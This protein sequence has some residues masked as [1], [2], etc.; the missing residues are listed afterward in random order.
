MEAG[1][2]RPRCR[3]SWSRER[4]Q[5][6]FLRTKWLVML[7][8]FCEETFLDR[9]PVCDRCDR[10]S[11]ASGDAGSLPALLSVGWSSLQTPKIVFYRGGTKMRDLNDDTV[12]FK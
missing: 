3:E 12:I 8:R 11:P 9:T 10:K 2:E 1:S 6:R 7:W 4:C 5:V